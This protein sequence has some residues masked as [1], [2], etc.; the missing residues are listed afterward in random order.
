MY[1]EVQRIAY[2][3]VPLIPIEHQ[4][5]TAAMASNVVGFELH[6]NFDLLRIKDTRVQEG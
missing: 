4:V 3:D 2:E 5:Q 6:P 1:W